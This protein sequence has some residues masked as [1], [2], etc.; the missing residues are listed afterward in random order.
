MKE[1]DRTIEKAPM[2]P[3][4]DSEETKIEALLVAAPPLADP[5]PAPPSTRKTV[6]DA[7][8]DTEKAQRLFEAARRQSEEK[9]KQLDDKLK[10]LDKDREELKA[11]QKRFDQLPALES[12]LQDQQNRLEEREENAR[13]KFLAERQEILG[14]I[15]HERELL[16][17]ERVEADEAMARWRSEQEQ[18]WREEQEQRQ[19]RWEEEEKARSQ[20]RTEQARQEEREAKQR[21]E[22]ALA[23]LEAETQQHRA[24]IE[25][26]RR[27]LLQ[28]VETREKLLEEQKNKLVLEQRQNSARKQVLDEDRKLLDDKIERR[29]REQVADERQQLHTTRQELEITRQERD[30]FFSRLKQQEALERQLGG[31]QPGE[32]LARLEGLEREKAE[33]REQLAARPAQKERERLTDLERERDLWGEERAGLQGRLCELEAR[34]SRHLTASHQLESLRGEK[35]ALEARNKLI[36]RALEELKATVDKYTQRADQQHPVAVLVAMDQDETCERPCVTASAPPEAPADLKALV[37]ELQRGLFHQGERTRLFYPETELR[38]FLAGMA[39]SR[40]ALLQGI[41]GTGKTSLP[42]GVARALGASCEV[43]AVQAGWRDRQDLLGHYNALHGKYHAT[44][45]LQ[46]L[47]KAH[48]P[49]CADRPF[50]VVLDEINLS[51]V[52]QFFADL[53]SALEQPEGQRRVTILGEPVPN[54]PRYMVEGRHLPLPENVWFVGTANHDESTVEFADKTYDR[55]HIMELERSR[56]SAPSLTPFTRRKPLSFQWLQQ[57][58]E[59]AQKTHKN[60]AN[61]ALEWLR[62]A[63]PSPLLEQLFRVRWGNRFERD[64]DRFLPVLIAAGGTLVEGLDHLLVTK[65]LRKIRD[66]HDVQVAS[67]E[68]LLDAFQKDTT[69]VLPRCQR[70]IEREIGSK[71]GDALA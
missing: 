29:V 3:L 15:T 5:S 70:L 4:R 59:E 35:E 60:A 19:Q 52:E 28:A 34:L 13:R 7:I 55:A 2:E 65:V 54:A 24:R 40:L 68:K 16:R 47:Y 12:R 51:R 8:K 27:A 44:N 6:T 38:C 58:F 42:I 49:S 1:R 22:A 53:L 46:A 61:Q 36:A 33:L 71:G 43:V 45:F 48:T 66:R 30:R 14:T 69:F 56:L 11:Q 62:E 63:A 39:Q 20:R 31:A 18:R 67:L 17:N 32:I 26:E 57:R 21:R 64:L 23:E 41:S 50:L 37:G 9:S 10:Q 25:Q